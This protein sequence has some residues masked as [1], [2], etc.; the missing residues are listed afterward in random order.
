MDVARPTG[1]RNRELIKSTFVLTSQLFAP[2]SPWYLIRKGKLEEAE[3]CMLA[4]TTRGSGYE[5]EDAKK[6]VSMMVHTDA[7]EKEMSAGVSFI[8]CF[9]GVNRR[10][11]EIACI[12]WLIQNTC[13]APL[14]GSGTYFLQQA[15]VATE[16]ASTLNLCM[17]AVGACGTILSWPLMKVAGRRTLYLYG[18][19]GMVTIMLITGILGCLAKSSGTSYAT[20]ALLILFAGLYDL[21]VGPVC[22]SLVAEMSSTRLRAKT[23]VLSRNVYNIAGVVINIINPRMLNPTAWNLGAKSAFL[24]GALG[25]VAVFWT[26]FRLPE[27]KGRTFGELDVLFE[28]R[29]PA[30]KFRTTEVD[31]FKAAERNAQHAALQNGG[32]VH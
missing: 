30:R 29:V 3:R 7:M 23:V 8:D 14:M 2:E 22:Y 17:Y 15:G 9:R 11:T 31:E 24:W 6:S 10:R 32:A 12:V 27:P 28:E 13:G 20:G 21:T 25:V 19:V 26:F 4:I 16:T 5:I 18:Q 1:G